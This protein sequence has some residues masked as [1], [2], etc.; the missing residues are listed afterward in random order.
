[1]RLLDRKIYAIAG[2]VC[3]P[4]KKV[5][6]GIKISKTNPDPFASVSY[7][8]DS[9][10]FSP[11]YGNNGN[12]IDNGW[13]SRFPF[14]KIRPCV[15]KNG[16]VSYYLN[17]NDFSKTAGGYNAILDGTDGD[18]MIEFPKIWYSF[19]QDANY[20]YIKY[21]NRP[22]NGFSDFAMRYKGIVREKFYIG[23]YLS[24][25]LDGKLRC[26]SGLMPIYSKS[27]SEL[28][29]LAQANGSGYE[30]LSWNKLMLLQVLFVVRFKSID[31]Q[32]AL[33]E[34]NSNCSNDFFSGA[35][36]SKGMNYGSQSAGEAVKFCGLEDF[37]GGFSLLIDGFALNADGNGGI[38]SCSVAVAD[39]NFNDTA[40]GYTVAGEL[41]NAYSG[42]LS[43]IQATNQLG[44]LTAGASGSSSTY[45]CD[46]TRAI[47]ALAL[48]FPHYGGNLFSRKD[49]GPFHFR[50][51]SG[52][53]DGGFY[54]GGRLMY[55]P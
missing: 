8:D 36:N 48:R 14:S 22:G 9:V 53:A 3:A 51:L 55:C 28:R 4:E 11:S 43:A 31:G 52:A 18:V 37:W 33:G 15:L 40:S 30:L 2:G 38:S 26:V 39:G 23:A 16:K 10:G 27:I 13:N 21:S 20:Y 32:T 7:T 29:S 25:V 24:S 35:A 50:I 49:C 12:F 34:G 44:F 42:Y 1:M 17:P 5:V 19:S 47:C 45:F 41:D 54:S 46:S 6:Y